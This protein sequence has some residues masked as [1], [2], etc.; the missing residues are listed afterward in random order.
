MTTSR[1]QYKTLTLAIAA[2][3][4]LGACGKKEQILPGERLN[5][6]GEVEKV[7][8]KAEVTQL[9][10]PAQQNYAEW[11][12]KNGSTAHRVAHPA[13]ATALSRAWS[14][15]IGSG[16]S[17]KARITSDPIVVAGRVFTLDSNAQI[18][19]FSTA[20]TPVWSRD[21]TPPWDKG[22]AASGGGIAY[23]N[24]L[25]VA[26]TGFGEVIA[27][28][29]ASGAIRW[30]HRMEASISTAPLVIDGLII[31]VNLNNKA[32]A[33]DVAN[34]RIQWEIRSGG[35][36]TGLSGAGAPAAVGEFL[37]LPFSSGELVGANIKTGARAW[38]A[39]VSGGGKGNARG[40]VGA[41]S[42]DPVIAGDTIYAA[43]QA[44][45]LIS[46]DRET[47]ARNWTINEG[48]YGP[49]W[50][51]GDSVFLVTDQFQ[52]KRLRASDGAE[53]WAVPLPGYLKDG[54][55]RREAH[56]H[57]GPVLAGNRLIVAGSDGQ[58]RSYNA[59]TGAALGNIQIPGGAASQPAIVN[60]TMYILSENGQLHA[61]K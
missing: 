22:G 39:A 54:K 43:N 17:K 37:A 50:A 11:T 46:A 59:S 2:S 5:L 40:F 24:G 4:A 53:M 58:I 34:G 52:L 38:S 10:A 55:R 27:M 21:L 31:A 35:S 12:H 42:G 19:A 45:R 49:V 6:R 41:I 44:G 18:R 29:P 16:N 23:G 36:S 30:R 57:Y 20:G 13:L 3:L 33:L 61:F 32:I 48:S 47:G 7:I 9:A 25:I 28:D 56:V 8:E 51:T 14:V 1:V 26:T 15:N 60:G